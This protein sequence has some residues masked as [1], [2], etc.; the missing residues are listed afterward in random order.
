MIIMRYFMPTSFK[1]LY[2]HNGLFFKRNAVAMVIALYVYSLFP[3]DYS[4]MLALPFVCI[5]GF[6]TGMLVTSLFLNE[7]D[8]DEL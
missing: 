6:C 7:E 1:Q 8:I 2:K 3:N 5:I 4:I